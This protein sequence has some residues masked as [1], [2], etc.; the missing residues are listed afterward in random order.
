MPGGSCSAPPSNVGCR[1]A[2]PPDAEL[3]G[4]A[5]RSA[6][7]R[8]RPPPEVLVHSDRGCQYT[9]ADDQGVLASSDVVVSFSRKGNGWDNAPTESFFASLK[10][11]LWHRR[12]VADAAEAERAVFEAI[13]VFDHR[14]RLHSSRGYVSPA[15]FESR[16]PAH[17]VN[18]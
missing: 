15:T 3:V 11:D 2:S 1:R 17:T 6:V 14:D 18:K 12:S 10:K 4:R 5:F 13:E 9:S 16:Q 7:A 8:R